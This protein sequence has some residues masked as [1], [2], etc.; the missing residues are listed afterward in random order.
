MMVVLM[1]FELRVR[2]RVES[3]S[4]DVFR[5]GFDTFAVRL[6]DSVMACGPE[7][8]PFVEF[9]GLKERSGRLSQQMQLLVLVAPMIMGIDAEYLPTA[10][11]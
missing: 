6:W 7:N 5:D 9:R 1:C 11:I 10:S 8:K 4:G 2:Y 3:P